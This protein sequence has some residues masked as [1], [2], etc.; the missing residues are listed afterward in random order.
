MHTY[1]S[2]VIIFVPT[3][4]FIPQSMARSAIASSHNFFIVASDDFTMS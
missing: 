4:Y 2:N 3:H 1:P